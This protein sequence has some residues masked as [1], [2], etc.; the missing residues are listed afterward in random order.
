MARNGTLKWHQRGSRKSELTG[1][2][3]IAMEF[4][5]EAEEGYIQREDCVVRVVSMMPAGMQAREKR[6]RVVVDGGAEIAHS[7]TTK[8]LALSLQVLHPGRCIGIIVV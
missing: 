1:K 3:L 8:E 6:E 2:G 4:V 5:R 7:A